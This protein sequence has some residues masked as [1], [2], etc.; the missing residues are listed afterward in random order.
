MRLALVMVVALAVVGCRSPGGSSPAPSPVADDAWQ[1]ATR[2]GH[3]AY[4]GGELA[5]ARLHYGEALRRGRVIEDPAAMGLAAYHVA[6]AAAAMADFPG[7]EIAL[8]EADYELARA[9]L[10]LGE[11]RLL[12]GRTALAQGRT[13]EACETAEDLAGDPTLLPAVRAAARL[14]AARCAWADGDVAAALP[15]AGQA[16]S[17]A[18]EAGDLS[19]AADAAALAADSAGVLERTEEAATHWTAAADAYRR[20]GRYREMA[21]ARQ[22]AAEAWREA[23]QGTRAQESAYQAAKSLAAW[24]ETDKAADLARRAAFWAAAAGDVSWAARWD[25]FEPG[26]FA[27]APPAGD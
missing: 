21:G 14:L 19:V 18:H 22:A 12:R 16:A 5:A 26:A 6:A 13:P 1:Q 11:A 10:P 15:L 2:R 24:G 20:A 25:A 8:A 27:P 23:G 7:A 17:M 4:R 9:D 3:R